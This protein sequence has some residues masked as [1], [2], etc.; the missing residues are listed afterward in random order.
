MKL[1]HDLRE[2]VADVVFAANREHGL[3]LA[4]EDCYLIADAVAD[5]LATLQDH[6][7]GERGGRGVSEEKQA[8]EAREWARILRQP[9]IDR[10]EIPLE[11]LA[12]CLEGYAASL[13]EA[14]QREKLYQEVVEAA[15]ASSRWLATLGFDPDDERLAQLRRLF[16]ALVALDRHVLGTIETPGEGAVE[17]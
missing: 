1:P 11:V 6:L 13:T 2:T 14:E 7:S 17:A 9:D 4:G 10:A 15:R 8:M 12:R 5:A 3:N 16:D